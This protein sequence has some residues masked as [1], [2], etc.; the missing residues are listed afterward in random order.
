MVIS[1]DAKS[2]DAEELL[3]LYFT[4]KPPFG[5]GKK[6]AEFPDAISMLSLKSHLKNNEK[7]YIISGDGDLKLYCE[8]EAQFILVETLDKL[9]DIYTTH[10]N[11]R[12][13]LVKE[14]IVNNEA[15]IK[16]EIIQYIENC[17][18]WNSSSW[19]GTVVDGG[20]SVAY[21]GDIEPSVLYIDDKESLVTFDIETELEVTVTGSDFN[22]DINTREY[23]FTSTLTVE[24][25]VRYKFVG[26]TL[27]S[28][29]DT[30]QIPD[31][32]EGMEVF[33]EEN[34]VDYY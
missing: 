6:K 32:S 27:E 16:T 24:I 8:S 30:V 20:L 12:H 7:I 26:E 11:V 9:L 23:P 17:D 33:I 1:I 10:T 3:S 25:F 13:E 34:G 5:D 4:K 14:Y 18:V 22:N 19:E 15:T 21:L 31:L 2:I 28:V 29:T